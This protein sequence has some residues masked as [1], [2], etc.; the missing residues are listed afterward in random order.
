MSR[1]AALLA[2]ALAAAAP[3]ALAVDSEPTQSVAADADVKAARAA[4]DRRDWKVAV[5]HLHRAERR[6]PSDADV[7][8]S[9]GYAYR[10]MG[11]F[12]PAFRHYKKAL[13]LDPRHR[14]AHE[15]I[16]EAYLL[17]GDVASAEKHLAALKSICLLPCEELREL[18]EAIAEHR[19]KSGAQ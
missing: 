11:Q 16:G 6:F 1:L 8:N 15:Y 7:Q 14:G 19:K 12:E 3:A 13:S 4:H 18:Q 10:Q 17:T 5:S 9:L 2:A